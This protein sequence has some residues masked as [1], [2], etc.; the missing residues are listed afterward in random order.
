MNLALEMARQHALGS[1]KNIVE[2]GLACQAS[3]SL[4]KLNTLALLESQAG[5]PAFCRKPGLS[6]LGIS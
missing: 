5:C 4:Q 3:G 6:N 1:A 2:L